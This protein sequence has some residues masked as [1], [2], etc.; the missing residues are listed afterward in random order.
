MLDYFCATNVDGAVHSMSSITSDSKLPGPRSSHALWRPYSLALR[1]MLRWHD[2]AP[3]V[4]RRWNTLTNWSLFAATTFAVVVLIRTWV[5]Y[6]S[7]DGYVDYVEGLVLFHQAQAAAGENVYDPSFRSEPPYSIPLY[8]PVWYYL[9]APLLDAEPSLLPGRAVSLVCMLGLTGL[10][11]W[12]LRKWFSADWAVA[13]AVSIVWMTTIGTLQFGINNRVDVLGCLLGALAVVTA[14]V[15]FRASWCVVVCLLLG[16]AFTK[17]TA[18]VAPALTVFLYLV[19]ER[20]WREACAISVAT[21]ACAAGVLLLGDLFSEGN[22]SRCLIFSNVNPMKPRQALT[23]LKT[24]CKQPVLPVGLVVALLLLADRRARAFALY[25]VL[26]SVFAIFSAAKVGSNTNYF[27]E[28]SWATAICLGIGLTRCRG[29]VRASVAYGF[30]AFLVIHSAARATSHERQVNEE[31]ADWP[32]VQHAVES[33]GANGPLLTMEIGAQVR[34]GQ[35]PYVADAH[36]ITRLTEAGD[37]NQQ[38]ILND[39]RN[40]QLTALI[41]G[42]DVAL[43]HK[44]HTNWTEEMRRTIARYYRPQES[45]GRLTVYLP[46]SVPLAADALEDNSPDHSGRDDLVRV[47]KFHANGRLA[48]TS[49]YRNGEL[50]GSHVEWDIG[51]S[52]WCELQYK[53]GDLEGT[54]RYFHENGQIAR[55]LTYT[56]GLR[57]G[58]ERHFSADGACHNSEHWMHGVPQAFINGAYASEPKSPSDNHRVSRRP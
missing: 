24:V 3:S 30:A 48:Q 38:P 35:Q 21:S 50:H 34:A 11:C 17:A 10:A 31:L 5:C 14:T 20:R 41:L 55:E 7:A 1:E 37:F 56:D 2:P 12:V 28:P 36:I 4:V 42:P 15:R 52:K 23:L 26:A 47:S 44:G 18:V 40:Q 8:G 22:F 6:L 25:G 9:I 13:T 16:A 51:G 33:Y 46:R 54:Q 27:I 45:L 29:H 57:H 49:D 19:S 53:S 39:L 43:G 32:L 58:V